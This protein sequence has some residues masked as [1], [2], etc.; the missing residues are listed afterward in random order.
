MVVV[1]NYIFHLCGSLATD[2]SAPETMTNPRQLQWRLSAPSGGQNYP[3]AASLGAPCV[4]LQVTLLTAWSAS[5]SRLVIVTYVA[6]ELFNF[7][8]NV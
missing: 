2:I 3:S 7:V 4:H 1:E 5:L 8:M 6:I